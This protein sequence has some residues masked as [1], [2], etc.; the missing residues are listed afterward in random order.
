MGGGQ[1]GPADRP[2]PH[3]RPAPDYLPAADQPLVADWP[4]VPRYPAVPYHLSVRDRPPV[5]DWPAA[6]AT[7]CRALLRPLTRLVPR[8]PAATGAAS[9]RAAVLGYLAVPLFAVPVLI[10]LTT[11]RGSGWARR[12]AAQAVNVWFT[13]LLYDLSAVIMGAMLA[14]GSPPVALMVFGPLVAARW[15]VTLAYLVRA[16][17]AAGRGAACTFPAWLCMRLAR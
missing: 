15:L 10:Y 6:P 13:G 14:L 4:P 11:L 12:H 2:M 8:H 1:P 3:Y 7:G 16:A 17:R 9:R 5:P